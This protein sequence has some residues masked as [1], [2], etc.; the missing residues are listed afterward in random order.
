MFGSRQN[1]ITM[2]FEM[3]YI[4]SEIRSIPLRKL[5]GLPYSKAIVGVEIHCRV[6]STAICNWGNILHT[7]VCV[8][9]RAGSVKARTNENLLLIVQAR[10][11]HNCFCKHLRALHFI[12][13]HGACVEF[14]H[15]PHRWSHLDVINN[16]AVRPSVYPPRA[17][18]SAICCIFA[19]FTQKC[20]F[21]EKGCVKSRAFLLRCDASSPRCLPAYTHFLIHRYLHLSTLPLLWPSLMCRLYN[22]SCRVCLYRSAQFLTAPPFLLITQLIGTHVQRDK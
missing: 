18:T 14:R 19:R 20:R 10:G 12:L 9:L 13:A 11:R 21:K 17:L 6:K 1:I 2:F 8:N 7:R 5:P 4:R 15:F 22:V 3:V 16:F